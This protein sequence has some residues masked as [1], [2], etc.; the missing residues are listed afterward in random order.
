VLAFSS[1]AFGQSRGGAL[2][3]LYAPLDLQV[4][5]T[6][7]YVF[8]DYTPQKGVGYGIYSTLDLP[9]HFGAEVG[10]H[11]ISILQHKPAYERTYDIGVRY[12]RDYRDGHLRPYLKLLYGR[13][14]FNFP[15]QNGSQTSVGNLAYNMFVVGGGADYA[16]TRTINVRAEIEYQSWFAR[17]GFVNGLT[18]I[19]VTV[20]AAYH[21]SGKGPH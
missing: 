1:A 15:A 11:Q 6:F 18:P 19:L 12:H 10:F 13:G 2:P 16:V 9:N 7:S 14:V 21:F 20:G 3:A 4:G 8:P 5:G 17:N